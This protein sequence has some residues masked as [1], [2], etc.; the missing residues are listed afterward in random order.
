MY[1]EIKY[2]PRV[3]PNYRLQKIENVG[4]TEW[5][6]IT[7]LTNTTEFYPRCLVSAMECSQL[8]GQVV[9]V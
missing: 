7:H 6:Y 2:I 3:I 5:S 1:F 8:V 4:S 9:Y